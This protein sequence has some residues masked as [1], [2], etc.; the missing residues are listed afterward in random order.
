[1]F[2]SIE[3]YLWLLLYL[4]FILTVVMRKSLN[5]PLTLMLVTLS[6]LTLVGLTLYG[7][8]IGTAFRHKGQI[9][10]LLLVAIAISG[11]TRWKVRRAESTAS[12]P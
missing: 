9:L 10:P 7:G 8:N 11:T 5:P 4:W 3:N 1:L 6:V 2:V 12:H